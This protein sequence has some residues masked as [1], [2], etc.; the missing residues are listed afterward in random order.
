MSEELKGDANLAQVLREPALLL[1]SINREKFNL[2]RVFPL[3]NAG[4]TGCLGAPSQPGWLLLGFVLLH[5]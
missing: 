3:H 4:A 5:D 2:S 1:L